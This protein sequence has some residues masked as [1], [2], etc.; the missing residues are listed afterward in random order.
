MTRAV[1]VLAIV[2]WPAFAQ[3]GLTEQDIGRVAFDPPADAHVPLAAQ[4]T[5]L[6]GHPVSIR[7]AIDGRPT[8][9]IPADFTCQQIC[10]FFAEPAFGVW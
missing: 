6:D 1:L 9:L 4:F 5:G 10:V 2:L 7:N 3:A 8:L